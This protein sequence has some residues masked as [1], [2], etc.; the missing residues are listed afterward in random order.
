MILN[1][2]KQMKK[3]DRGFTIVELLIVIVIIAVLAAI[4]I[5]AYTGIQNRAKTTSAQSAAATVIK[6]VETYNSDIGN[7]PATPSV[8]TSAATT[9]SYYLS[10]IT[11]DGT[12]LS[13][14]NTP[15]SPAE[16][17]FYKCGTGSGTTAPATEAEVIAQTGVQLKYWSYSTTAAVNVTTG[18]TSGLVGTKNIGCVL[19]NA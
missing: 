13:T 6:K 2:I 10:G 15:A 16:V 14:G 17:N 9:T 3:D 8:L 11:F 1:K 18:V 12:V 7:Y 4:T 5:V 19:T